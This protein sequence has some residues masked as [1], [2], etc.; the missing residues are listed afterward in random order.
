M[1]YRYVNAFKPI[2]KNQP[3]EYSEKI[4]EAVLNPRITDLCINMNG[5]WDWIDSK[6]KFI[7]LLLMRGQIKAIK[8]GQDL[9]ARKDYLEALT[10]G[11]FVNVILETRL[12]QDSARIKSS[13][14]SE[15]RIKNAQ[16][17]LL[18]HVMNYRLERMA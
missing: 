11:S 17:I 7:H 16:A 14:A 5:G 9:L 4:L 2:R 3:I 18:A 10:S 1:K 15:K 8:S 12:N 6:Y 13:Y